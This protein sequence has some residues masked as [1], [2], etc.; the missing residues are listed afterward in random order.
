M[1]FTVPPNGTRG[2]RQP[3]GSFVRV[4]SRIVAGLYRLLGG[5]GTGGNIGLL[6]TVGAKSGQRRTAVAR[7]FPEGDR[8]WLVVGSANGARSHP[9]WVHNMAHDPDHVWVEIRREKHRVTPEL[10]AGDERE[11]AW[12]RVV[13]DSP[14]FAKYLDTTDRVLTIIRLTAAD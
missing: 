7:V 11:A 4:G 1:A 10:L 6:T 14:N 13:R 2:S 5:A 9:A 8:E 3:S 12:E